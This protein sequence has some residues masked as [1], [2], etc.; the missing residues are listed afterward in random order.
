MFSAMFYGSLYYHWVLCSFVFF[1]LEMLLLLSVLDSWLI[2]LAILVRFVNWYAPY[3]LLQVLQNFTKSHKISP[4][5]Y[6]YIVHMHIYGIWCLQLVWSVSRS[7]QRLVQCCSRSGPCFRTRPPSCPWC[8][9]VDWSLAP[10][11]D[12]WQ[13]SMWLVIVL[14]KSHDYI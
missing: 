2:N 1:F 13:V 3:A 5:S 12:L 9:L 11:T 4:L 7:W 10:E 14:Y 8:W 6:L